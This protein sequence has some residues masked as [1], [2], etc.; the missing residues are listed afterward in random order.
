MFEEEATVE[1]ADETADET[2]IRGYN[3]LEAKSG[4]AQCV[5]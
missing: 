3:C 1:T 4:H 2:D 5:Q